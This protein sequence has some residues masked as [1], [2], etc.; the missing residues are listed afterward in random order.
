MLYPI[1]L[2]EEVMK[3][4]VQGAPELGI[5]PLGLL[6]DP[7]S[8]EK[9][10][11]ERWSICTQNAKQ[12]PELRH[13]SVSVISAL[14]Y[15][16][17]YGIDL[18]LEF[19]SKFQTPLPIELLAPAIFEMLNMIESAIDDAKALPVR[20]DDSELLEDRSHCTSLLHSVMELWAMYLVIDNEYQF[21]LV[22]NGMNDPSFKTWMHRL[23]EAFSSL[24]S[25]MQQKEQMRLL[26]IVTELPILDNWR[27][28]LVKEYRE[29]LPWW[30]DGTLE[31]VAAEVH[32]DIMSESL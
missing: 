3:I 5:A 1:G 17:I 15:R 31:E 26:S 29:Y 8:S 10:L 16:C 11:S 19:V 24:D 7:P 23:L 2:Q 18:P 4:V 12:S 30:L 25:A 9:S 21:C 6:C 22:E 27:K 13:I 14:G 32:R 28:M 20:F